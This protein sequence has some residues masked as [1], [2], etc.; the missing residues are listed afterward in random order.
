MKDIV[1]LNQSDKRQ[2]TSKIC[3][4]D[5]GYNVWNFYDAIIGV[6]KTQPD[7]TCDL[8]ILDQPDAKSG[9]DFMIPPQA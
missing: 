3:A 7:M 2:V 5:Y 9:I 4:I 8:A 6:K 1:S